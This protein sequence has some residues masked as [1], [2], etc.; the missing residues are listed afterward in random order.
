MWSTV[1]INIKDSTPI[2]SRVS[3]SNYQHYFTVF[4]FV[5]MLQVQCLSQMVTL[6]NSTISLT[7]EPVRDE[8]ASMWQGI[9][10]DIGRTLTSFL[11]LAERPVLQNYLPSGVLHLALPLD[12]EDT[13]TDCQ[14]PAAA[15]HLIPGE[16]PTVRVLSLLLV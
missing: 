14:D 11:P 13:E 9:R 12:S 3:V 6:H 15:H 7:H 16:R 5:F 2:Y 4:A 10:C 8:D 1:I